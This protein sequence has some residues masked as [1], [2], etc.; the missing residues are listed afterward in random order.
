MAQ[1]QQHQRLITELTSD[2]TYVCRIDADGTLYLE[3]ATEGFQRVTGYTPAGLEARGGIPHLIHPEDLPQVHRLLGRALEGEQGVGEI[4]IVTARGEESDRVVGLVFKSP[5]GPREIVAELVVGADGR[6][7]T[8]RR[9][10]GLNVEDLGAPMDVLWMRISRRPRRTTS[11]SF[12]S[13][14][15]AC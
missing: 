13:R 14:R 5:D 15:A 1:S 9:A 12:I 8:V 7:S 3:A 10:A 2:Y 11:P 6:H 4:R